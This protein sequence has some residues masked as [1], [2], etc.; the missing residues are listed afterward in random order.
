MI[1]A[2]LAQFLKGYLGTKRRKESEDNLEYLVDS[3]P[4]EVCIN[5][6]S[7]RCRLLSGKQFIGF[8]KAKKNFTM[9]LNFI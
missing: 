6:R 7:Y 3:M 4:V 9:V 2:V 1:P 8:C 5:I